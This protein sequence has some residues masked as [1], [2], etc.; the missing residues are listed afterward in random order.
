MMVVR[1]WEARR[2]W[3]QVLRDDM[4]VVVIKLIYNSNIKTLSIVGKYNDSINMGFRLNL[5]SL[6]LIWV[7]LIMSM[8]M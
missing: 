3:H 4:V 7:G 2:F 8:L 1:F 6:T 5:W